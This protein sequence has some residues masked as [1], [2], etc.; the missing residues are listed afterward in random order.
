MSCIIDIS[1]GVISFAGGVASSIYVNRFGC[2]TVGKILD[3][4]TNF[5]LANNQRLGGTCVILLSNIGID[6]VD[7]FVPSI[8]GTSS[9]VAFKTGAVISQMLFANFAGMTEDHSPQNDWEKAVTMLSSAAG[10]YWCQS[11]HF[12]QGFT[13]QR[14]LP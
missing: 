9:F 6:L 1:T 4:K 10:M 13:F 2:Q 3:Q 12:K 7:Y 11:L 14:Q 8:S 5:S